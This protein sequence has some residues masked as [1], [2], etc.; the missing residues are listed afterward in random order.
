MKSILKLIILLGIIAIVV[1]LGQK[2]N[3]NNTSPGVGY[4]TQYHATQIESQ[5]PTPAITQAPI[6]ALVVKTKVA[7]PIDQF[8]TRITKK[9]YGLY[10]TPQKSPVTPERFTG[11]HT[12]VDVEYDDVTTDV[13]VYAIAGGRVLHSS[14]V[15]GYGG[16]VAISYDING[17]QYV[18]IYGH[19]RPSSM[20][21]KGATVKYGEPIAVLG[22]AFTSETSGERRHLHLSIRANNSLNFSGYVQKQSDLSGWEDPIT[23]LHNL[24][25]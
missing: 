2:F 20:V 17:K 7:L 1:W 14:S 19:L 23:F 13:T 3:H 25:L 16:T 18:V 22:T 21:A 11:F 6:E 15:G 9:S 4:V 10:I 24:G 5:S 12:G 8:F